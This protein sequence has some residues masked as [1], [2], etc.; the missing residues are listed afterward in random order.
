[1]AVEVARTEPERARGLMFRTSLADGAGMLFVFD[2]TGEHPFW[3][4]NTLIPLDMIFIDDS[5]RITG[6]VARA[7]P[8]ALEPRSGGASRFVLEVNGGWAE[9]RG[10]AA[11]D[12]V[13]FEGVPFP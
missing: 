6:V 1:V 4:K 2:E 13:R 11:G 10:V 7:T 3:M 8:G 9:A 12:Q 5:G